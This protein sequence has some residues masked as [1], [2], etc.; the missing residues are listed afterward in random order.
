MG[1]GKTVSAY[2]TQGKDS[3]YSGG[4]SSASSSKGGSKNSSKDCGAHGGNDGSSTTYGGKTESY[5]F[6]ANAA[7]PADDLGGT[8]G[9]RDARDNTGRAEDEGADVPERRVSYGK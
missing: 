4:D 3:V 1:S 8:H 9:T 7:L 6:S 5:V 2:G